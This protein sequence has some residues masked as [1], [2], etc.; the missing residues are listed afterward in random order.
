VE[1]RI[2]G[3]L[4]VCT[5]DGQRQRFGPRPTKVLAALLLAADEVVPLRQM[6]DAVWDDNPPAT[7]RRQIH[8]C[9]W[10]LRKQLTI[11][12][13]GPGYR[14]YTGDDRVDARVF[15]ALV[16][17]A[18]ASVANGQPLRAIDQL[19]AAL[20][21]WRGPALAGITGRT[22]EAGAARLDEQRL[23][24]TEQRVD[25]EL[26][27]GRHR[28][29]TGEL[30]E[31]VAV[32][33]LRERFVGQLMRA[34][35][36][37]GRQA[38]ALAA[39][40]QL[41][42]RLA[43][44]LGVDPGAGVQWL[45]TAIL[46]NEVDAPRR[47]AVPAT[48]VVPRQLPAPARH[49]VGR[50]SELRRLT[51]LL[52]QATVP[53]TAVVISAI[54]GTAGIGKTAL[55]LHWAHRVAPRFP[56]GQLYTNMRGF[57]PTG[58]PMTPAEAIRGFLDAL[59][60]P[61]DMIPASLDAQAALYRSLLAD[62]RMLIMLDN[63]R[64]SDQVRPLLPGG[65][66]CVAVVTSRNHLTSLVATEGAHPL[67]LD[68]LAADEGRDLLARHVGADRVT[69]EPGAADEII[70][71]CARLPLALTIAAA[72]AAVQPQL[73]LHALA[74]ELRDVRDR[75]DA[76]DGGTP[77]I[78]VRTVFSWSYRTL[79][80]A[81]ARLFR[82][83][84]LHPGPDLS[85]PAAASLA[86]LPQLEVRPLL[87]ELARA[88]LII[89]HAP[90][91]YT[92]HDLLRAYAA[93]R[94]HEVDASDQ[95]HAAIRRV[96]DHYLYTAC[97]A[98]RLLSPH[99]EPI[100]L[101]PPVAGLSPEC[102]SDHQEA[103]AWFGAEHRVLLAAVTRAADTGFDV[104]TWQLSW[105]LS[106]FLY[107][108]G[109]WDD[110]IATQRAALAATQRLGDPGSELRIR[111]SLGGACIQSGRYGDA[112]TH[113]RR[114]L[115][116]STQAGDPSG[117]ALAHLNL[118]EAWTRQDHHAQ[119]LHHAQQAHDLFRAAGNRNRQANALNAIGWCHAQLGHYEHALASCEQALTLHEELGDQRGQAETWDS[120]G[121]AHHRLGHHAE[122][123]RCY[124]RALD[125]YRFLGN[126]YYQADTLT[127]L[128]DTHHAAGD[129]DAAA[130]AWHHALAIL[131][132]LGHPAAEQ[133]RARIRQ[134]DQTAQR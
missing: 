78:D 19:T 29:L 52:D 13:D 86:G 49:F 105:I 116:L 131:D 111:L 53:G 34:L 9:V 63:A 48:P 129:S 5:E 103:M 14:I 77:T 119:A 80:S 7:A 90:G 104:H 98:E 1:F 120:V 38:D 99:R 43:D 17:E 42:T 100:A 68:V 108:R 25:L 106:T 2:L 4:Q 71:H 27:L 117:A 94:A 65:G 47:T 24:A 81:T 58:S 11:V 107:R 64:D 122:A 15:Q 59:A 60:V 126:R 20:R 112:L 128:G 92:F 88:H 56:D 124:Q 74:A 118:T 91:R 54:A 45:H 61:A 51:E 33:P 26:G 73:P 10:L 79:T 72:H 87:A 66:S 85:T 69:A 21:L 76:L 114:A 67:S 97:A 35:Y 30:T 18:Q 84:G 44:E 39:Y 130:A 62:R 93:E 16:A 83:L 113:L 110:W 32:H 121:Y 28:E 46:R 132:D 89:E 96:L 95:R 102:F 75:L 36:A 6:I 12:A 55:A 109:H 82:L 133:L 37:S 115:E 3:P 40:Q 22:I 127:H 134:A 125:L 70:T 31:L 23:A 101:A 123:V 8:N 57:D 50:V 41:R